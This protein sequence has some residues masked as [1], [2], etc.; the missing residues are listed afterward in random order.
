MEYG[1][2]SVLP[3]V[4]TIV[5]AVVSKNVF[6]SLFIGVFLGQMIISGWH[7]AAA[8]DNTLYG[9]INTFQSS[10]NTITIASILL[11]G[12]I[13][14]II[15][16]SGGIEGFVEIIVK[17]RGII[18]SKRAANIFTWLLG[19]VVFT[20]GSLSCMVVG[21]VSRPVNDALKVPHE[22]AAFLVHTTSTPVCVLLPLSGWGASLIG[23]LTSGGVPEETATAVMVQTIG[24]NFYCIIEVAAALIL[25]ICQKDFGPMKKAEERAASTGLLDEPG[26][27][28]GLEMQ[29]SAGSGAKPRVINLLLPIGV[30]IATIVIVLF[31]SGGGN[32]LEGEGMRALLWGVFTSLITIWILCLCEGLYTLNQLVD[33]TFKG[34]GGMLSIAMILVFGFTMGT[35][36]GELGTGLYLSSIFESMLTP[37]LLPALVFVMACMISLAT[38]TSMGTMAITSVIALPMAMTL[39][40]NVPLTAAA[41]FGGSIFGDHA[42]PVSDTTIMSC[43]TTGCNIIDHVKTQAPYCAAFALASLVLYVIF[44]FIMH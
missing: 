3:P 33:V 31:V 41:V 28:I 8:L 17:K 6:V 1:F 7:L 9:F 4:L 44:G 37:A 21:S 32:L 27:G 40:V 15:E 22:K 25:A 11:I 12:A 2:L 19:V 20:S 5:L 30:L 13:I 29:E 36:V 24:L 23:Y 38:G 14:Y 39:G 16:C 26:S 34:A 18:G 35:V 10:S 42:S 43:S